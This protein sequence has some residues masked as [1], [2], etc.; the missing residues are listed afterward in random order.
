MIWVD[1]IAKKIGDTPQHI[2]DMFTPS[3]YAHIGSLRGPI[4][5]DVVYRVLHAQNEKTVFTYVLNDFDVIDGLSDDLKKTHQQYMGFSLRMAPSP[6]NGFDSFAHFYAEEMKRILNE[7]GVNAEYLSSWDMYHEGRFN[8]VIR[9][10]LDHKDQILESYRRIAG[11]GGKTDDWYPFH[12][13]CPNCNR[14]GTTKVVGWDGEKVAYRCEPAMVTWAVGCGHEGTMSPFDGNGKLPWKVDWPAHWKTLGITFEG[15]G[16]DHASRGGS[17]DI[18][19]DLTEKVFKAPKPYY[20]PYEFFTLGGKKMSSSK[21]IG[22]SSKDIHSILP[23]EVFRFLI[24]RTPIERTIE[25]NPGDGAILDLF[26]DYDRCLSA[27]YD[28]QEKLLGESKQDDVKRDWA[29][30]AELSQVRPFPDTGIFTPRFRTIV[31]MIKSRADILGTFEQQK[32]APFSTEEKELLEERTVYAQA[33]LKNIQGEE[34][35]YEMI[36][37]IPAGL[38]LNDNQKLFLTELATQLEGRSTDD[39]ETIQ[40][41]V[42]SSMKAHDLKAREVFSAL[43]QILIGKPQGPKAAD[44]ILELGI[45]PVITRIKN[46]SII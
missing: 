3:G 12:V 27:Y 7:L 36:N 17:Y 28:Q 1:R 37:E 8:D 32:G 40:N 29:R 10:A 39:R 19:F 26:D 14:L 25:F 13:I 45:E 41:V 23:S 15:A 18:A 35:T 21:G 31:N 24:I 38:A 43:Y 4:L 42:F 22:A 16:K 34:P 11:Y 5:H 2:D 20:F 44:L 30:I 6:V 46:T 9:T 33:Y